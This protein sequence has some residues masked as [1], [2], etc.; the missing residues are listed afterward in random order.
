MNTIV[1]KVINKIME[2]CYKFKMIDEKNIICL[3]DISSIFFRKYQKDI[4][5]IL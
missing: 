2:Q 1:T 4:Q 3:H 5:S